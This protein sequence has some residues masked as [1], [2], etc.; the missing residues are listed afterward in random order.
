VRVSCLLIPSSALRQ[1]STDFL[2]PFPDA[3]TS[4]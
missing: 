2:G 4:R 3:M 1:E